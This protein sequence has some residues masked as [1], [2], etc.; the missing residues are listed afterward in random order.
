MPHHHHHAYLTCV[1]LPMQSPILME[2]KVDPEYPQ[3]V[4]LSEIMIPEKPCDIKP[5]MEDHD[6]LMQDVSK[7]EKGQIEALQHELERRANVVSRW[8]GNTLRTDSETW[9]MEIILPTYADS[10]YSFKMSGSKS[11]ENEMEPNPLTLK[12]LL[13][14]NFKT[15]QNIVE[16][17]HLSPR[18][19]ETLSQQLYEPYYYMCRT[20]EHNKYG[21]NS[22]LSYLI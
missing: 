1:D 19:T 17:V 6:I 4:V 7:E 13:Q 12:E 10:M 16:T 21:D 2:I 11:D 3:F 20:N 15:K 14:V 9:Q 22:A 18:T 8:N 5:Y